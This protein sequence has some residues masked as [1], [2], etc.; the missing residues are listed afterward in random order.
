MNAID[1]L[2]LQFDYIDFQVF[3]NGDKPYIRAFEV[4]TALGIGNAFYAISRYVSEDYKIKNLNGSGWFIS[5]AGLRQLLLES[6]DP[7]AK[8]YKRML[9]EFD[10]SRVEPRN[11]ESLKKRILWALNELQEAAND[12]PED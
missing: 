9:L 7:I 6:D 12:L 5:E 11:D 3:L 2:I 1:F 4:T 8:E 10:F